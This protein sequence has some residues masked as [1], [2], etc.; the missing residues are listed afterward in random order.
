MSS[1]G[2]DK[3]QEPGLAWKS[4]SV[5]KP[6]LLAF[7]INDSTD[8]QVV[9]Q[10]ACKQAGVPFQWHIAES[11]ER[12]ISYLDSLVAM[13]R[14]TSVRWPDLVILD[15]VM[16]GGSG[17]KVLQHIRKTAELQLLPVIILTGNTSGEVREEAL[18][19]GANSFHIKPVDFAGMVEFVRTLYTIWS[20]AKRPAL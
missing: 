5:S 13:S 6:P 11:S 10:A 1:E 15:V 7:H 12:G 20:I 4:P 19:F 16:P 3:V 8:D 9:F 14:K 2:T 18:R 17:L